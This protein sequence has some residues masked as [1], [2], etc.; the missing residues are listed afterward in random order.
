MDI[1]H[2]ERPGARSSRRRGLLAITVACPL[3][4]A[5][6]SVAEARPK[7]PPG[8]HDGAAVPVMASVVEP[9]AEEAP[10]NRMVLASDEVVTRSAPVPPLGDGP[11]HAIE[12]VAVPGP[13]DAVTWTF[14]D[15]AGGH[16]RVLPIETVNPYRARLTSPGEPPLPGGASP[17]T[18]APSLPR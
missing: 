2:V 6:A 15:P 11:S 17:L 14:V 7:S 13:V 12:V 4:G 8:A 10:Q 16:P 1:P 3:I 5:L 9:V 18:G